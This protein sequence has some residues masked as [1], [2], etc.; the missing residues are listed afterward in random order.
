M[1]HLADHF[2][3]RR[4]RRACTTVLG[5]GLALEQE[6]ARVAQAVLHGELDLDDVL[7]LGQHRRF[8]QA[9]GAHDGVAADVDRSGS[10]SRRP[11][12][13]RWIGYGRRQLKPAPTVRL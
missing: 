2:A 13:W 12:S 4:S 9:G 3:H 5:R 10:A 1:L 6:G 8:A 11:V 7:V